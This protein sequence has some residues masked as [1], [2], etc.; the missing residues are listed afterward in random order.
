MFFNSTLT[1]CLAAKEK[2]FISKELR[3]QVGYIPYNKSEKKY[4]YIY[5]GTQNK[6]VNK[7]FLFGVCG[8]ESFLT[9]KTNNFFSQPFV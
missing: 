2:Y 1:K 3:K 7:G 5:V 9:E 8:V 4:Y 6:I